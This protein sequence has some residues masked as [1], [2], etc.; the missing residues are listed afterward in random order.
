MT[1]ISLPPCIYIWSFQSSPTT[2]KRMA[3]IS[4]PPC[5]P[6][7][8]HVW[9]KAGSRD[10][11]D[12][13]RP[14]Y[15]RSVNMKDADRPY[16]KHHHK[17]GWNERKWMRWVCRNGGM[18]F[19]AGENGRNSRGKPTQTP[20]RSPRNPYGVTESRALGPIDGWRASNRL[21]PEPPAL[22]I[23]CR[24]NYVTYPNFIL[25]QYE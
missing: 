8:H 11:I 3:L 22:K 25:Y 2:V 5:I 23:K 15:W 16:L 13:M 17:V 6:S 10:E 4:L 19:V 7:S 21:R 14:L 12:T 20:F 24:P 9:H 1:L 18:K